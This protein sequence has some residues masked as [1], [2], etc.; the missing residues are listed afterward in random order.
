MNVIIDGCDDDDDDDDDD[1][2]SSEVVDVL[3]D[4]KATGRF[5]EAKEVKQR[6]RDRVSPSRDL[7]HSD[8]VDAVGSRVVATTTKNSDD[9]D[10]SSS[11]GDGGGKGG[12]V[13]CVECKEEQQREEED[14]RTTTPAPPRTTTI[15]GAEG[16]GDGDGDGDGDV[17][18]GRKRGRPDYPT[19]PPAFFRDRNRVSIEYSA[20]GDHPDDDRLNRAAYYANELLGMTYERNAWWKK[21]MEQQRREEGG[22]GGEEE[23]EEDLDTQQ[24]PPVVVDSVSLIPQRLDRGILV[25]LLF[26]FSA[27][28]CVT[29]FVRKFASSSSEITTPDDPPPPPPPPHTHNVIAQRIKLNDRHLF[30]RRAGDDD[31]VSTIDGRDLCE[32]VKRAISST[33]STTGGGGAYGREGD[34]GVV[35]LL[36][37]EEAEDARK[38]FGVF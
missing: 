34:G 32:I 23:E 37:D 10:L 19:I 29:S 7:G 30:E 16:R 3:W 4:R 35:Q 21:R 27:R 17:D 22:G 18:G 38:Y 12:V 36:D 28:S 8:V 6:V 14:G 9:D 25:S 33:G 1:D 2:E 24:A 11:I 15:I 20:G 26:S 5:P 13:D 31:T